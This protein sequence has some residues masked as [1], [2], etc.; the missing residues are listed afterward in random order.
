[1]LWEIEMIGRGARPEKGIDKFFDSLEI[2]K[3][4]SM[5]IPVA[6]VIELPKRGSDPF[7]N[8]FSDILLCF[9]CSSCVHGYLYS[10]KD[11]RAQFKD[12]GK[13]GDGEE[14]YG[15]DEAVKRY[16]YVVSLGPFLHGPAKKSGIVQFRFQI[17]RVG[18]D[19]V[20]ITIS[21]DDDNR[22]NEWVNIDYYGGTNEGDYYR[23]EGKQHI[24]K[25]V[26]KN[27]ENGFVWEPI[28]EK[29]EIKELPFVRG[30]MAEE[31]D[32][33]C[34]CGDKATVSSEGSDY[35][36]RCAMLYAK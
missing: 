1:M 32:R 5:D 25:L 22:E 29:P 9:P 4:L 26:R 27:T 36:H 16:Q 8:D 7:L 11:R 14:F 28:E 20:E 12:L 34:I 18:F 15:K 30:Y 3:V 23:E 33:C 17:Q 2:A 13:Y 35:C 21:V 24:A 31:E 10:I 6:L 19:V